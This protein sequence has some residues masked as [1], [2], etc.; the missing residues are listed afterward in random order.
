MAKHKPISRFN[1]V[2]VFLLALFI[3]T[4]CGGHAVDPEKPEAPSAPSATEP[5]PALTEPAAEET[6]PEMGS[7][8]GDDLGEPCGEHHYIVAAGSSVDLEFQVLMKR[9]V[10]GLAAYEKRRFARD[11]LSVKDGLDYWTKMGVS[12]GES[13][14]YLEPVDTSVDLWGVRAE[15]LLEKSA[16]DGGRLTFIGQS[17][18]GRQQYKIRMHE[19]GFGLFTRLGSWWPEEKI[20]EMSDDEVYEALGNKMEVEHLH[21]RFGKFTLPVE[22]ISVNSQSY[23]LTLNYS[24]TFPADLPTRTKETQLWQTVYIGE[25]IDAKFKLHFDY[26]KKRKIFHVYGPWFEASCI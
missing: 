10:Y 24:L 1:R 19:E 23:V 8:E 9:E 18:G 14:F 6:S 4:G 12:H 3:V 13:E 2:A 15:E 16:A 25:I 17:Q 21:R 20:A 22:L 7:G 5:Q 11:D 26:D